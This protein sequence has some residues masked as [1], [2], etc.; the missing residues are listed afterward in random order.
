MFQEVE[1][2][3]ETIEEQ[4]CSL[5]KESSEFRQLV[6]ISCI[7]IYNYIDTSD[8]Q[9]CQARYIRLVCSVTN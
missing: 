6:I 4:G 3:Q 2:T 7:A 8:C 9:L 5:L 1:V